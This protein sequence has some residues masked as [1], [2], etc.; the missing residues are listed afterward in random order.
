[1]HMSLCSLTRII[2]APSASSTDPRLQVLDLPFGWGR[3]LCTF[4]SIYIS[5]R[6]RA[7]FIDYTAGPS[8]YLSLH[9]CLPYSLGI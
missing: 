6:K 1:M 9:Q 7:G 4:A 8:M 2:C 3:R 5:T